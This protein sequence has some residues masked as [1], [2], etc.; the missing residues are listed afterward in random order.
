MH[1]FCY[2]NLCNCDKDRGG[3]TARLI[4]AS[5]AGLYQ[6]QLFEHMFLRHTIYYSHSS[7]TLYGEQPGRVGS[8]CIS[9]QGCVFM[10]ALSELI[11]QASLSSLS[12]CSIRVST[13]VRVE[14]SCLNYMSVR[15]LC[16]RSDY[17]R[18]GGA[19]YAEISSVLSRPKQMKTSQV[20]ETEEKQRFALR[21]RRHCLSYICLGG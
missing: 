20:L 15:R 8:R 7:F 5:P 4:T 9:T 10:S 12:L 3:V 17:Y 18:Q 2:Y 14:E 16:L 11:Q 13:C 6:L 19:C 21:D 1:S